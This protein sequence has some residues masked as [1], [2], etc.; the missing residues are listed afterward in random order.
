[1]PGEHSGLYKHTEQTTVSFLVLN[2]YFSTTFLIQLGS[3]PIT[4]AFKQ[5]YE[6]AGVV[7]GSG[8]RNAAQSVTVRLL[9]T[10][11]TEIK[12]ATVTKHKIK[13]LLSP[14]MPNVP[15]VGRTRA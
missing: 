5:A 11:L 9:A 14:V 10:P 6:R 13:I 7:Q 15:C 8:C 1:M 3:T 4:L 12:T 2:T